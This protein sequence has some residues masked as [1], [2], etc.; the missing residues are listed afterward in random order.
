[1]LISWSRHAGGRNR[2]AARD[3]SGGGRFRSSG[4]RLCQASFRLKSIPANTRTPTMAKT[5]LH[6][7]QWKTK[8]AIESTTAAIRMTTTNGPK[9][10]PKGF[11]NIV[12]HRAT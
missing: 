2:F 7:V 10:L 6:Q 4:W 5:A 11:G 3:Q 9:R 12:I 1:V 8:M